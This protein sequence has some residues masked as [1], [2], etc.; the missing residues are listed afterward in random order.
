[1]TV[2]IE[3]SHWPDAAGPISGLSSSFRR[4][5]ERGDVVAVRGDA[6][7]LEVAGAAVASG[8][9]AIVLDP[10]P[11]VREDAWRSLLDAARRTTSTVVVCDRWVHA[12]ATDVAVAAVRDA[13][14]PILIDVRATGS[15]DP[16]ATAFRATALT[17][18]L[19]GRAPLDGAELANGH[20]LARHGRL[21]D[22]D[23]TPYRL[24]A[25]R[26]TPEA[27]LRARI[28]LRDGE[29][30]LGLPP[31]NDARAGEV[32]VAAPDGDRRLPTVYRSPARHA[33]LRVAAALED[34]TPDIESLRDHVDLLDDIFRALPAE[35]HR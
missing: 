12:V 20:W 21:A 35:S 4:T 3:A 10:S 14:G 27:S 22:A 29:V 11:A 18:R 15:D 30:R 32:I 7:G 17:R 8:R 31:G 9:S 16:R 2:T 25:V 26:A 13:Q 23:R 5:S 28:L 24:L 19:T 33:L 34:G 1:M 6:R